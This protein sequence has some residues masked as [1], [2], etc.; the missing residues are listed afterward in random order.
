MVTSPKL[1]GVKKPTPT[2]VLRQPWLECLAM[3]Y[4]NQG[5]QRLL[6]RRTA[7]QKKAE[8]W[9]AIRKKAFKYHRWAITQHQEYRAKGLVSK[10][11]EAPGCDS[12]HLGCWVWSGYGLDMEVRSGVNFWLDLLLFR[13]VSRGK[14]LLLSNLCARFPLYLWIWIG[15]H[16]ECEVFSCSVISCFQEDVLLA[17]FHKFPGDELSFNFAEHFR[18]TLDT[19]GL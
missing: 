16:E 12:P 6:E 17:L 9:K 10:Q 2:F 8:L 13:R 1:E 15:V 7:P 19:L 5:R 11:A 4:L 14:C 18:E 3:S